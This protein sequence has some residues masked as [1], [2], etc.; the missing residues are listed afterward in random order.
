MATSFPDIHPSPHPKNPILH[1][2][3]LA[4]LTFP[5]RQSQPVF[6]RYTWLHLL[7]S[8]TP[9]LLSQAEAQLLGSPNPSK[10]LLRVIKRA[11]RAP[12][13]G[14]AA[15]N[16]LA[17]L[18][19]QVAPSPKGL[20]LDC[21]SNLVFPHHITCF[22][23]CLREEGQESPSPSAK[24]PSEAAQLGP[25]SGRGARG[26]GIRDICPREAGKSDPNPVCVP[27]DGGNILM[28]PQHTFVHLDLFENS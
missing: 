19:G 22:Y 21:L 12:L 18:L 3:G 25:G 8:V 13:Q 26:S 20:R 6:P 28:S 4:S 16:P 11:S 15:R 7:P 5:V 27:L 17:L 23:A 24:P 9:S 2:L 10:A 1:Y 14:P